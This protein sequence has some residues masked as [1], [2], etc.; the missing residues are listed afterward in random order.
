MVRYRTFQLRYRSFR[1]SGDEV[2]AVNLAA[3]MEFDGYAREHISISA[4]CA[5]GYALSRLLNALWTTYVDLLIVP[6]WR[7]WL[8]EAEAEVKAGR[9]RQLGFPFRTTQD[10]KDAV[11]AAS[12]PVL[13]EF[14]NRFMF[15]TEDQLLQVLGVLRALGASVRLA[16]DPG[17]PCASWRSALS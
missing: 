12:V 13:V 16:C 5:P 1:L 6:D 17:D 8:P 14:D 7:A 4:F 15:S 3:A 10:M 2:M 9:A 11:S